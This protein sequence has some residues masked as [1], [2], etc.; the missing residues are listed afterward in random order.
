MQLY[1]RIREGLNPAGSGWVM[2][3]R[4]D[5]RLVFGI[6]WESWKEVV[7]GETEEL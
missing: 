4:V 5:E 1:S 6:G 7:Q 2:Y 3:G